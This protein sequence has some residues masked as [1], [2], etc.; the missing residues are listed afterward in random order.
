LKTVQFQTLDM[1]S[2]QI[3]TTS[4]SGFSLSEGVVL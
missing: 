3:L 4:L 1:P 2:V